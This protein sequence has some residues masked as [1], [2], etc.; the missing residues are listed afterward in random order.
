MMLVI[1]TQTFQIVHFEL[2]KL[3]DILISSLHALQAKAAE[4][5]VQS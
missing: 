5:I 2:F 4:G 3:L 1:H